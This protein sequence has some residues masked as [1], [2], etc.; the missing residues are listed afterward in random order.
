MCQAQQGFPPAL[1]ATH[2]A[3]YRKEKPR[4]QGLRSLF[5]ECIKITEE[6]GDFSSMPLSIRAVLFARLQNLHQKDMFFRRGFGY[7][8]TKGWGKPR[9]K[10]TQRKE[11]A[12]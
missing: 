5:V 6:N 7:A 1:D 11:L 10:S 8:C 9:P 12:S 2:K 4:C 3:E